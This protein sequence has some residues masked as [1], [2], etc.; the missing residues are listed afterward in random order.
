MKKM[1]LHDKAVRL[2]EGGLV[3]FH[4]LVIGAKLYSVEIDDCNECEMDC[5]CDSEMSDLCFEICELTRKS[6][7]LYLP[8][9]RK[10]YGKS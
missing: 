4:D 9:E 6:C 10:N 3:E 1:S 8:S 5:L 2:A 7:T